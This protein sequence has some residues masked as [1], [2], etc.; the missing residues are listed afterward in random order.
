MAIYDFKAV[1]ASASSTRLCLDEFWGCESGARERAW[2]VLLRARAMGSAASLPPQATQVSFSKADF[3]ELLHVVDTSQKNVKEALGKAGIALGEAPKQQP[4][5]SAASIGLEQEAW[6]SG[7]LS[8][9]VLGATGDLAKKETFP[10]LLD[11]F[12]HDYL[13]H[14]AVIVGFARKSMTTEDFRAYLSEALAKSH[15]CQDMPEVRDSIPA[16][17]KKVHYCAGAYDSVEAMT[18]LD[19]LLTVEEERFHLD[20]NDAPKKQSFR[21]FYFAIPPFVFQGA[22]KAI[23]EVAMAKD[24]ST[25]LIIEKPFGHDLTSAQP[26]GGLGFRV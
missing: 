4:A 20:D 14:E 25:R 19:K 7:K 22:A 16:F 5:P 15:V 3:E 11:L 21:I 10:A 6:R 26:G 12:A 18:E 9:T 8:V 13:Q 17:L 2:E 23:K 24:G 1:S